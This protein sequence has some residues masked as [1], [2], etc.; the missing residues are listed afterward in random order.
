MH[1]GNFD[2]TESFFTVVP[3]PPL[4][5]RLT[6]ENASSVFLSWTKPVTSNGIILDYQVNYFGF[7]YSEAKLEDEQSTHT[8]V[9]GHYSYSVSSSELTALIVGLKPGLFYN[10]TVGILL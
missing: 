4:D 5:L 1:L 10:F 9:E 6:A 2:H 8:E 7:K 3:G